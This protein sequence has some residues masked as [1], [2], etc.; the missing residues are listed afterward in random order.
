MELPKCC[1]PFFEGLRNCEKWESFRVLKIRVFSEKLHLT[2]SIQ[3]VPYDGAELEDL[4]FSERML[5]G[6]FVEAR[7][8]RGGM[9]RSREKE[10]Q[11]GKSAKRKESSG[12][13]KHSGVV[14]KNEDTIYYTT[15][16]SKNQAGNRKLAGIQ[17]KNCGF[18]RCRER[19]GCP[20]RLVFCYADVPA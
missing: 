8:Q 15:R 7:L 1:L 16:T 19:L 5:F 11:C 2:L 20:G 12:H 6:K 17:S 13:D 10:G 14:I 18:C 4:R 9:D 3:K